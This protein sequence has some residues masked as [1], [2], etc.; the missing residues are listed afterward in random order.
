MMIRCMECGADMRTTSAHGRSA[1]YSYYR[2]EG[3]CPSGIG[4]VHA[5]KLEAVVL[6]RLRELDTSPQLIELLVTQQ[7]NLVTGKL[8]TLI[9]DRTASESEARQIEEKLEILVERMVTLPKDMDASFLVRKMQELQARKTQLSDNIVRLNTEMQ[10]MQEE[11]L[12]PEEVRAAIRYVHT[13]L[14]GLSPP[15]KRDLIRLLITEI[16]LGRKVMK[17]TLNPQ[18]VLTGAVVLEPLFKGKKKPATL[19]LPVSPVCLLSKLG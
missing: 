11:K 6:R 9:A 15:L 4:L 8:P 5:D 17:V 3:V 18:G 7:H 14:P 12:N 13:N 10:S 2:H 1:K 16:E 19:G